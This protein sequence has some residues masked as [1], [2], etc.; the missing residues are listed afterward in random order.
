MAALICILNFLKN[1]DHSKNVFIVFCNPQ[2][3]Y[4]AVICDIDRAITKYIFF[5]NGGANLHTEF[6]ETHQI[7]L[8]MVLLS[9][10]TPLLYRYLC[11]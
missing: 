8:K 9:S 10:L 7:T 1:T 5:G 6:S 4:S 11:Y 2:N 3:M